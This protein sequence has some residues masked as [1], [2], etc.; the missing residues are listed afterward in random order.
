MIITQPITVMQAKEHP[1]SQHSSY[2]YSDV[3]SL[4]ISPMI[5][6]KV[7]SLFNMAVKRFKL[8][9]EGLISTLI[10]R[11]ISKMMSLA[12]T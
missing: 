5:P 3:L 7:R 6:T 12:L 8:L 11:S 4:K 2:G 9:L 1:C 10:F